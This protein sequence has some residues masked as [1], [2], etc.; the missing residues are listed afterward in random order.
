M[1][2]GHGSAG[3][4]LLLDALEDDD[5]GVG[6]HADREDQARDAR[7]RQRDRDQ[8]DQREE[9]DARRRRAR[10]P[11][12]GR[13]RGRRRAGRA[14]RSRKPA[15]PAM[16][17]WLSACLPSV[18]ETCEREISSSSIG[19]APILRIFARSC[20][21]VDREAAGDLRAGRAVDAVRVLAV[22]DVRRSRRARCRARS[23]SAASSARVGVDA[24]CALSAPRWAIARVIVWNALRPLSVKSNVTIGSLPPC[25]S[26]FCSGFLMS[27][28]VRPG[29]SRSTQQR[30]GRGAGRRA[31]FSSRSDEHARLDLDD[32]GAFAFCG[33]GQAASSASARDSSRDAVV[34]RLLGDLVERVE[35][36]AGARPAL[37]FGTGDLALR[38]RA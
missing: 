36:R 19:S 21:L 22:V 2:G 7:Q 4:H 17:P 29:S 13:A 25:W 6:R 18:A 38:R 16:R 33:R 35:A 5:V 1:A 15:T 37:F 24:G 12:S 31:A 8:L 10:R 9:V 32:L 11:R 26:K 27:V 30:S 23:R 20:A 34:E 28:P 14:R 3:A